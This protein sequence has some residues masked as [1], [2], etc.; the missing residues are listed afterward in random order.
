MDA[1]RLAAA[2]GI[3]G[4]VRAEW[5]QNFLANLTVNVI[6]SGVELRQADLYSQ[7]TVKGQSKSIEVY[8]VEAAVKDAL[9]IHGQCSVITGLQVAAESIKLQ[10]NPGLENATEIM[11]RVNNARLVSEGKDPDLNI[12]QKIAAMRTPSSLVGTI[13]REEPPALDVVD[14]LNSLRTKQSRYAA[15]LPAVAAKGKPALDKLATTIANAKCEDIMRKA[16]QETL[17]ANSVAVGAAESERE[18]KRLLYLKAVGAEESIAEQLRRVEENLDAA[19]SAYTAGSSV[20]DAKLADLDTKLEA[21]V[22]N[23]AVNLIP[24]IFK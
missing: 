22:T 2:A 14:E 5:N 7:V 18:A 17:A 3:F 21:D 6:V 8:P 23:N 4:G 19:Y 9:F 24:Q 12:G 13:R 15:D 16:H 20:K 10:Q 11:M 1:K